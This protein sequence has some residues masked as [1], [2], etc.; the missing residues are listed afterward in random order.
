MTIDVLTIGET[1]GAVRT[2]SMIRLGGPAWLSIVGAE[3]NVA[4]GLARLGHRVRWISRVGDDEV[5]ALILRCLRAEGVDVEQVL[6][7]PGQLTGMALVDTGPG[8]VRR[9]HYRRRTSPMAGLTPAHLSP[10]LISGARILHITGITPAL[11][12]GPASAVAEVVQ[13]LHGDAAVSLD[14]NFR[15]KLWTCDAAARSL[16]PLLPF[17]TLL[18]ASEDELA[19]TSDAPT[20][21]A[22]VAGLLDRGV[23]EVVVKRGARGAS[24]YTRE[25]QHDAAALPA[26]VM[27]PIGAGDAFSAG[28]LSAVLDNVGPTERLRRGVA[29]GA[30]A[31]SSSGDW[32]G[33]PTRAELDSLTESDVIR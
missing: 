24:L 15:S 3:S 32:E 14:V 33:L 28:Y 27:D 30:A 16:R 29:L 7:A 31:V 6:V 22:Q 18:I 20:E 12:D 9:V 21:A 2:D 10:D 13:R 1:L 25:G 8:G 5:G 26:R 11:G 23:Q 4:I 19:I 17:V